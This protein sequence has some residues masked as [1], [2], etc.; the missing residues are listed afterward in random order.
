MRVAAKSLLFSV[1]STIVG[2]AVTYIGT[3]LLGRSAN[4][5]RKRLIPSGRSL[6]GVSVAFGSAGS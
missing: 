2:N 5:N 6:G 3:G 1:I 4:G